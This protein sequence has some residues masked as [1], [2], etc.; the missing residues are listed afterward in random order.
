[1]CLDIAFY[2]ALELIDDYFPDL[3]H[4]GEI[5]FDLDIGVH[6]LAMGYKRYPV[7]IFEDDNYKRK[8]FEWCIIAEYMDTPE[9][10]RMQRPKMANARAERIIDDKK[11]FWFR[12]HHQRCLI[13]VTGIYEHRGIK[14]WKNKVPYYVQLKGR[15]MFCLPG[16]Y[17]YNKRIPS[18]PETGEIRG[19]F[20]M[21]TRAGNEVMNKIHNSGENAFR[22]PLFLTKDMEADWLDPNLTD[23]ELKEILDYEMPSDQLIYDPVFSIRGRSPRPDGQPK[24]SPFTY[25]DLPPL[26][27]DEGISSQ[28]ELF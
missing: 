3:I 14:G 21:I 2:S 11:S 26:G 12:I 15:K 20:S 5:D 24:N 17:H 28:R 8:L 27:E 9:K 18:D 25:K 10:V 1:M 4:D 19:M 22:M 13:P 7:I 6:V 16:L 23:D